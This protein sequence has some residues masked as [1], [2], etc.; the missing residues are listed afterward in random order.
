MCFQSN[1]LLLGEPFA[2]KMRPKIRQSQEIEQGRETFGIGHMRFFEVEAT[3]FQTCKERFNRPSLGIEFKGV[4]TQASLPKQ[5]YN[6]RLPSDIRLPTNDSPSDGY[7]HSRAYL[8]KANGQR[9]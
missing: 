5:Q 8:R 7:A 1:R 3:R 6:N 2:D 4:L 9:A